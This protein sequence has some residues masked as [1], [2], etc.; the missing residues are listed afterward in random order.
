MTDRPG[1]RVGSARRAAAA[2]ALLAA[3]VVLAAGAAAAQPV[4]RWVDAAG[5]VRYSGVPPPAGAADQAPAASPGPAA[6]GDVLPI[7]E[8]AP[9]ADEM[10]ELSGIRAQLPDVMR[11][12]ASD[13]LRGR[14]DLAEP[15]R[16]RARA[17][18][19]GAFDP[20]RVYGLVRDAYAEHSPPE[21]RHGAAA[22]LRSPAGRRIVALEREGARTPAATLE[23]FAAALRQRP[24]SPGRL[25][26]LE[27]LDWV[28]GSAELSADLVVAV[29]RGLARGLATALPAERRLRPGQID[30]GVAERRPHLLAPIRE[31][32]RLRLLYHFRDLSDEELREYVAF[33]SSADGRA[34][35]RALRRAL[36]HALGAA[37]ERAGTELARILPAPEEPL[38]APA[39]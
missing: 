23:A 14:A 3:V 36:V 26:L 20:A 27:R 5:N 22:W 1:P 9:G 2:R 10:L 4:Y 11:Q 19:E 25:E 39:R 32:L 12:L 31:T 35:G 16:A 37:S 29:Q 30:T 7:R 17:A 21:R 34:H 18:L 28:S 33:E 15:D 8:T 6:R 38:A 24:P 13:V